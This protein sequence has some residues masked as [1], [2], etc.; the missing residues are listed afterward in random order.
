MFQNR[1]NTENPTVGPLRQ[2]IFYLESQN[3][4]QSNVF[5]KEIKN[6]YLF[7]FYRFSLFTMNYLRGP[8]EE[9]SHVLFSLFLNSYYETAH[10][11]IFDFT[12]QIK[13]LLAIISSD[14]E[15]LVSSALNLSGCSL[16]TDDHLV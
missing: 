1:K 2:F 10:F 13:K 8:R 14:P 12:F 15:E 4:K 11:L 6:V 3:E 5:Q 16:P 9:F 7:Y